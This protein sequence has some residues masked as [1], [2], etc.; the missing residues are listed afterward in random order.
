MTGMAAH[1]RIDEN[2]NEIETIMG[3]IERLKTN[4]GKNREEIVLER[5]IERL[6]EER[7]ELYDKLGQIV[8][9]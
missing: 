7:N 4:A 9:E 3:I 5:V 1:N 6:E 2:D 8:I